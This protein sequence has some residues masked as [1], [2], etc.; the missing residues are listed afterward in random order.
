MHLTET[1]LFTL[2]W[3]PLLKFWITILEYIQIFN[4]NKALYN[5]FH[6]SLDE[7]SDV[8]LYNIIFNL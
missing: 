7:T 4:N 8:Y 5:E 1:D 6:I 2:F 3:Q